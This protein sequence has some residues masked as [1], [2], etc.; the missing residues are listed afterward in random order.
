M[1]SDD[2]DGQNKKEQDFFSPFQIID[3]SVNYQNGTIR[4]QINYPRG[5]EQHDLG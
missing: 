2:G 1:T 5:C 4:L 3:F